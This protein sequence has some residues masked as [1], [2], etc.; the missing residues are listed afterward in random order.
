[1]NDT[2]DIQEILTYLPQRYPILMIDKVIKIVP[3]KSIIALKNVTVNEPYFLGHF[4]GK[5]IMPGVLIL[6]AM[7]QATGILALHA[8]R[9][10]SKEGFLYLFAGIDKARFKRPVV[11]GDQL[12]IEAEVLKVKGNIWKCKVNAKVENELVCEAEL[13]GA[14]RRS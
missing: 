3:G 2:M 4:P 9:E 12:Y 6:E 1:M 7:A 14:G 5:P 10:R 11:P 8:N 13:M